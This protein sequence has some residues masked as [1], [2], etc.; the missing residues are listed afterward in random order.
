[1]R[2]RWPRAPLPLCLENKTADRSAAAATITRRDERLTVYQVMHCGW[3]LF[4][5]YLDDSKAHIGTST[6]EQVTSRTKGQAGPGKGV[7]I[8]ESPDR[9]EGLR[10]EDMNAQ[11]RCT[12]CKVL[13]VFAVNQS[14]QHTS[15]GPRSKLLH[16]H[17]SAKTVAGRSEIFL[18]LSSVHLSASQTERKLA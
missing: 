16:T 3:L 13:S 6:Y 1:M 11:I 14:D 7:C 9:G 17:L 18:V 4:G 5:P 8:L 15:N 12:Q 10:R 2:E